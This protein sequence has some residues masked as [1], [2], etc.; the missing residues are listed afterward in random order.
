MT[1][2]RS[3][4]YEVLLCISLSPVQGLRS[5]DDGGPVLVSC[6]NSVPCESKNPNPLA[7]YGFLTFFHK[8]LRILNQFLHTY[9]TFRSTLDY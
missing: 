5:L 2:S 9:Y 1:N 3:F 7:T 8:R 4:R 6:Q